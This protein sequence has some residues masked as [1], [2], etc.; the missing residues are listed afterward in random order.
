MTLEIK[1]TVHICKVNES[2]IDL[3]TSGFKLL[4]LSAVTVYHYNSSDLLPWAA[5]L[6]RVETLSPP[7]ALHV[8]GFVTK[9]LKSYAW[10][11]RKS[12]EKN[13]KANE[14]EDLLPPRWIKRVRCEWSQ[15]IF[16]LLFFPVKNPDHVDADLAMILQLQLC[17][18]LNGWRTWKADFFLGLGLWWW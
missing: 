11:C 8:D 2:S 17:G 10:Q 4:L 5:Q 3:Q 16:F 1:K 18:R 6:V 15:A 13:G 12:H 9:C 7:R 14:K